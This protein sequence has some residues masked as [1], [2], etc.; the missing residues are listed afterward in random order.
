MAVRKVE[1]EHELV[2][3]RKHLG[4]HVVAGR[5]IDRPN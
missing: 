4:E 5:P 3:P 1:R 2:S